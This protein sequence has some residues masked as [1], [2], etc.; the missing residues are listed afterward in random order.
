M[1]VKGCVSWKKHTVYVFVFSMS[2]LKSTI[3]ST[4]VSGNRW[5]DRAGKRCRLEL[6]PGWVGFGMAAKMDDGGMFSKQGK[7]ECAERDEGVEHF[8]YGWSGKMI[9]WKSKQV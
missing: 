2:R 8:C 4:T 7:V 1:N 6:E 3:T 5:M 9:Y